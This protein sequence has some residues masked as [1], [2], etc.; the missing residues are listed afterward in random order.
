MGIFLLIM[1]LAGIGVARTSDSVGSNEDII[2]PDIGVKIERLGTIVQESDRT[3]I[4]A[5]IKLPNIRASAIMDADTARKVRECTAEMGS[6]FTEP[7]DELLRRLSDRATNYLQSRTNILGSYLINTTRQEGPERRAVWTVLG[8]LGLA[9][10]IGGVTEY[11]LYKITQH[12]KNNKNS[13]ETM[14]EDVG[15]LGAAIELV[16]GKVVG[17]S[18]DIFNRIPKLFKA[19]DCR[20]FFN[21]MAADRTRRLSETLATVEDTL[22]TALSGSNILKLTPK[23]I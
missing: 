4:S 15:S 11:Q 16:H 6:T 2:A 21:V 7:Y 13:I 23:M 1:L 10:A 3:L 22:W 17:I 8:G 20:L 14:I 19:Q 18:N 9:M 12:V 5:I